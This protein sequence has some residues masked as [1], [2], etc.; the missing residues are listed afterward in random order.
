MDMR[1]ETVLS[2]YIVVLND[3]NHQTPKWQ[4]GCR[5]ASGLGATNIFLLLPPPLLLLTIS[6]FSTFAL[7]PWGIN[8]LTSVGIGFG[9]LL[10]CRFSFEIGISFGVEKNHRFLSVFISFFDFFVFYKMHF[11]ALSDMF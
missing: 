8:F 6:E 9:F 1:S 10:N 5:V 3:E 11:L 2:N 7:E 4:P